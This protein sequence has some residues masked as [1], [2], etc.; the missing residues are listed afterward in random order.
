MK[1]IFLFILFLFIFLRSFFYFGFIRLENVKS[2]FSYGFSSIGSFPMFILLY[3]AIL[4]AAAFTRMFTER[5]YSEN[6]NKRALFNRFIG[7]FLSTHLILVLLPPFL[8]LLFLWSN[9]YSFLENI[10]YSTY[11]YLFFLPIGS[12]LNMF[13]SIFL[14]IFSYL[15]SHGLYRLFFSIQEAGKPKSLFFKKVAR[16]VLIIIII[17][18]ILGLLVGFVKNQV[19]I[20]SIPFENR[21]MV[22]IEKANFFCITHQYPPGVFG[23]AAL[24]CKKYYISVSNK[25]DPT[26][27]LRY[28]L[29]YL[30]KP[31]RTVRN[32]PNGIKVEGVFKRHVNHNF[33]VAGK[34]ELTSAQN[35]EG[36][37]LLGISKI[38]DDDYFEQNPYYFANYYPTRSYNDIYYSPTNTQSEESTEVANVPR[39]DIEP[40]ISKTYTSSGGLNIKIYD[41]SDKWTPEEERIRYDEEVTKYYQNTSGNEYS[42]N[43]NT[44][45]KIIS[46]TVKEILQIYIDNP[47][48]NFSEEDKTRINEYKK[49]NS[50][51]ASNFG[52]FLP[53]K[54]IPDLNIRKI[55]YWPGKIN[56]HWDISGQK[57]IS[58]PD[59]VSGA[60]ISEGV[61]CKKWYPEFSGSLVG[62]APETINTWQDLS[63]VIYSGTRVSIECL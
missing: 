4:L 45:P 23:I 31:W 5:N 6:E 35:S 53:Q 22:L 33:E 49:A 46:P 9:S 36:L 56:Q 55:M 24:S 7:K 42:V 25:E 43:N 30:G 39:Q 40:S 48:N 59:G 3:L 32:D 18:L 51:N 38:V 37:D 57:W 62:H 44:Q 52:Y 61:Y 1:K 50:F 21:E 26:K 47:D 28:E 29:T 34:I 41:P 12:I 27:Y 10:T 20:S 17:R 8:Y 2:F 15:I 19:L 63:G 16:F 58:D 13:F 14:I 54:D 11:G 60:D